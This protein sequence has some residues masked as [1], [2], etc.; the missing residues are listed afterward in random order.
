MFLEKDR[1]V[2]NSLD[3][4]VRVLTARRRSKNTVSAS[5]AKRIAW[6]FGA[7]SIVPA[8]DRILEWPASKG[9]RMASTSALAGRVQV[10][11]DNPIL[12]RWT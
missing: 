1:E 6:H 7:T 8:V 10:P 4:P 12:S 11:L 2:L 9:S 3:L 5:P